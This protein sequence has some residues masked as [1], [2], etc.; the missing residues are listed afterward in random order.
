MNTVPLQ[1]VRRFG[2]RYFRRSGYLNRHF[3][4]SY[5]DACRLTRLGV[6]AAPMAPMSG[7]S[8]HLKLLVFLVNVMTRAV[9]PAN[10]MVF[11]PF[12]IALV[13]NPDCYLRTPLEANREVDTTEFACVPNGLPQ[14]PRGTEDIHIHRGQPCRPAV[15][16][17]RRP[18]RRNPSN[19]NN[20]RRTVMLMKTKTG[21]SLETL[22]SYIRWSCRESNQFWLSA[23]QRW[24][25]G[26]QSARKC[27][28][29]PGRTLDS[30][31]VVN[32]GTK[33]Q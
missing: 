6:T 10:R 21:Q 15:G 4:T 11:E 18:G 5:F 33:T 17:A 24:L 28:K 3:S 23:G 12:Q 13:L 7:A 14:P 8:T 16:T 19:I 26:I 9:N 25:R 1:R 22:T 31:G 2:R 32:T 20:R 30:V 29:R 27:A